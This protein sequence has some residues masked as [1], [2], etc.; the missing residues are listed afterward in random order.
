MLRIGIDASVDGEKVTAFVWDEGR[1]RCL[2][3]YADGR[4]GGKSPAGSARRQAGTLRQVEAL[5]GGKY[6]LGWSDGAASLLE[7]TAER[8]SGKRRK[9][10]GYAVRT[11]AAAAAF[12]PSSAKPQAAHAESSHVKPR[13]AVAERA[14]T[15]R[16]GFIRRS[17]AGAITRAACSRTAPSPFWRQVDHR[18]GD[19]GRR[20]KHAR[21]RLAR[22]HSGTR[23]A[24]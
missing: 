7:I 5:S 24:R 1:G 14:A 4:S 16:S 13:P 17:D 9:A 20:T 8:T 18:N 23:L 21:E 22:R 2:D 15:V 12:S 6:S 19:R 11:L 3:R 10:G